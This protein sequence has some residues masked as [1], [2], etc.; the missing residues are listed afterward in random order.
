VL[1]RQIMIVDDDPVVLDAMQRLLV[2]WGYS[3]IAFSRFD[4]ARASLGTQSPDALIVDI[5]LG[6]YNGLQ[7]VHIAKRSNPSMAVVV[8]SGYDDLVL[9]NEATQAGAVYLLKPTEL[10]RLREFLPSPVAT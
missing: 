4:E 6:E 3:T 1:A 7:L 8:V 9:R 2:L 10:T 5:R